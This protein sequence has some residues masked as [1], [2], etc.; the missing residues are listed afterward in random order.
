MDVNWV[1]K[2]SR[3]IKK[4]WGGG[5]R[6]RGGVEKGRGAQGRCEWRSEVFEKIK[7][8][9]MFFGGSVVGSRVGGGGGRGGRVGGVRVEMNEELKFL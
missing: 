7:K 3:K 9:I 4:N 2:L 5:G 8:K 6:V 1:L